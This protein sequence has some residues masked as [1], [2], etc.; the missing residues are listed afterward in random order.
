MTQLEIERKF[1]IRK[2][3]VLH[4]LEHAAMEQTY[5]VSEKG[6]RRVRSVEKNDEKQFYFTHKIRRSPLTAEETERKIDKKEYDALLLEADP[7]RHT[8]VKTRYYYPYGELLFEIDVYPFWQ[9][10]CVMEVELKCEDSKVEFPPDIEILCEVTS[11][12]AYKNVSLAQSVPE[13]LI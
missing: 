5:L 12:K 4:R 6:T 13:E 10:Q 8:I 2:P 3:L 7:T 9:H 11:D 1:I